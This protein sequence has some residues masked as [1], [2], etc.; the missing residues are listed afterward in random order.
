MRRSIAI[1]LTLMLLT[2]CAQSV[3]NPLHIAEQTTVEAVENSETNASVT[4]AT[5]TTAKETTAVEE[6]SV[7]IET[8]KEIVLTAIDHGT[9]PDMIPVTETMLT[10]SSDEAAFPELSAVRE[11]WWANTVLQNEQYWWSNEKYASP[12]SAEELWFEGGVRYDFDND[13]AEECVLV[14]NVLPPDYGPHTSFNG[15][16]YVDNGEVSMLFSGGNF[17]TDLFVIN[18]GDHQFLKYYVTAGGTGWSSAIYSFS[19]NKPV[20]VVGSDR[21]CLYITVTECGYI[22]VGAKYCCPSYPL[23]LCT[24]GVFRQLAEEKIT[25]DE[26]LLRID[27]AEELLAAYEQNGDFPDGYFTRGGANYRLTFGEAEVVLELQNGSCTITP[28]LEKN[29]NMWMS[30]ELQLTAEVIT[31]ANLYSNT[32]FREKNSFAYYL[33]KYTEEYGYSPYGVLIEDINGDAQDEMIMHINPFGNMDILYMK[34]G[35]IKIVNCDVMSI[36]GGTWYDSST[37]RIVNQYFY[38]HT[39][40]TLGAYEYYVYDWDGADYL[41]TMHLK[42]ESGYYEREPD[43]VTKTDIFICGQTYLNDEEITSERFEELHAVLLELMIPENRIDFV[44]SG[45]FET[46]EALKK[47]Q[48]EKYN[49]YLEE[50]LYSSQ[51]PYESSSEK[52]YNPEWVEE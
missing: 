15:I 16:F 14:M 2:G 41:L 23:V 37:N 3:D 33:D 34:D 11:Y 5:T 10:Q 1:L 42:M 51:M 32:D 27:G 6:E 26:F 20:A 31:G 46:D 8:G 50:K 40:G 48:E 43:G 18:G 17:E 4:T 49:T 47:S 7:P 9:A 19:D 36:W 44:P 28:D 38:G 22:E 30:V 39:E 24:D 29:D 52:I 45:A 13:G 12:Q 25:Q 21:D 35:V